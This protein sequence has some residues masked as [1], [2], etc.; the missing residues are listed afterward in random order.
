LTQSRWSPT[1]LAWR[2][3][4]LSVWLEH[5]CGGS[6][7]G[8]FWTL[9]LTFLQ[10]A[11]ALAISLYS[12]LGQEFEWA[13]RASLG[14]MVTVQVL[15]A[16]VSIL[17]DPI[18]RLE[19]LVSCFVSILEAGATLLLLA[20]NFLQDIVGDATLGLMGTISTALLMAS[21]FTPIVLSTYDNLLLPTADAMRARMESGETCGK[22]AVGIVL[23][24]ILLPVTVASA[25][26]GFNFKAGDMIQ[27]AV[28]ETQGT[29]A[30]GKMEAQ[31]TRKRGEHR[32]PRK[33]P[34][35][36]E[37][38]LHDWADGQEGGE[39]TTLPPEP[40]PQGGIAPPSITVTTTTTTTVTTTITG[41]ITDVT[42][43]RAVVGVP[44]AEA[45]Q[46]QGSPLANIWAFFSDRT[47]E[48]VSSDT[49][50]ET[51]SA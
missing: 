39:T 17:A 43:T 27:A 2:R 13:A 42:Q 5:G 25:V 28:D 37:E 12:A 9:L 47:T 49:F 1:C 20:S 46:P 50:E 6:F 21:V 24:L 11:M 33:V 36:V 38:N 7:R 44:V 14:I 8:C 30:D 45:A 16:L 51:L 10:M 18:D 22:A 26:L 32:D 15:M 35:D 19:G 48:G 3:S 23:Q 41:A 4:Q 34:A 29:V 31:E 40:Q